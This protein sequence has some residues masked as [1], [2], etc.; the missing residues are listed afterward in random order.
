MSLIL[1][2]SP[3]KDNKKLTVMGR[4]EESSLPP[5]HGVASMGDLPLLSVCC[6]RD[7]TSSDQFSGSAQTNSHNALALPQNSPVKP[8][9]N[10]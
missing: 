8:H 5:W 9:R 2:T 4:D 7:P 6:W 3:A 1:P 10:P